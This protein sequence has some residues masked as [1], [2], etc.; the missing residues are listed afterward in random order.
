MH[1]GNALLTHASDYVVSAH[2]AALLH[3][4]LNDFI[5]FSAIYAGDR[6]ADEKGLDT[7]NIAYAIHVASHYL[8]YINNNRVYS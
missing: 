8:Y 4:C 7:L 1:P 2:S 5:C 3:G 6:A